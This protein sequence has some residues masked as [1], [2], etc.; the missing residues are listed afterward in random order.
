VIP[1]LQDAHKIDVPQAGHWLKGFHQ[2][3]VETFL[4]TLFY[5]INNDTI[6]SESVSVLHGDLIVQSSG[7]RF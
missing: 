1:R 4:H 2:P 7:L 3:M 5:V 6:E